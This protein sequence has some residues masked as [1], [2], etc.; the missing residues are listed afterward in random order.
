LADLG[1][2]SVDLIALT[3]GM[4]VSLTGEMKASELRANT[5]S[6][7]DGPVLLLRAHKVAGARERADPDAA[8]SSAEAQGFLAIGQPRRKPKHF[9]IL[10]KNRDGEFRELHFEFDGS[11]RKTKPVDRS[12]PKWAAEL[13]HHQA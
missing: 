5:V 4:H 13:E 3:S 11:L 8:L 9:E 2:E 7:G 10:A 1:P 12:G 6:I